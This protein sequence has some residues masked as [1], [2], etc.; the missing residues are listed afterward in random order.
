LTTSGAARVDSGFASARCASLAILIAI[1][2]RAVAPGGGIKTDQAREQRLANEQIHI[3]A[4]FKKL[5]S[6]HRKYS[7]HRH[8]TYR[9]GAQQPL[10]PRQVNLPL[11]PQKYRLRL[12]DRH[13]P[14]A[15][16]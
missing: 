8:Y 4:E 15:V 14:E 2:G 12:N 11:C 13:A 3:F 6:P 5:F 9:L 7:G 16:V 10:Q 1:G